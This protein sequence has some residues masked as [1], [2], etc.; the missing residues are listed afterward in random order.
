M[1]VDEC[2][3]L[4]YPAIFGHMVNYFANKVDVVIMITL[5]TIQIH[6]LTFKHSFIMMVL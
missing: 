1:H 5:L 2:R 6:S 3:I 4:D